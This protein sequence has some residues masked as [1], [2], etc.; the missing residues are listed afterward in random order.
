VL[1]RR[2][3]RAAWG[4]QFNLERFCIGTAR[5]EYPRERKSHCLAHGLVGGV[6][7]DRNSNRHDGGCIDANSGYSDAAA[8]SDARSGIDPG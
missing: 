1:G 8:N 6:F 7:A 5:G 2:I 4:R 3:V